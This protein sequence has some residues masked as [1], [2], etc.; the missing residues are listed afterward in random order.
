MLTVECSGV[1][2]VEAARRAARV[3]PPGLALDHRGADAAL[4]EPPF[5]STVGPSVKEKKKHKIRN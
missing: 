3:V 2:E 5:A 1:A 4:F